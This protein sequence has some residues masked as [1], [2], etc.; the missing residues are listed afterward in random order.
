MIEEP[1][2][3]DIAAVRRYIGADV[4]DTTIRSCWVSRTRALPRLV[5]A[6]VAFVTRVHPR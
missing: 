5:A 4:D 3:D 6:D 1:S 2:D